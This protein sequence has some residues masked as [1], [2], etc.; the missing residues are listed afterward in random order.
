MVGIIRLG[1]TV[2]DK[3]FVVDR[4]R[5]HPCYLFLLLNTPGKFYV[6]GSWQETPAGTV[7]VFQPGQK[8]LYGY[9]GKDNPGGTYADCWT[10][11]ESDLPLFHKVNFPF[12]KPIKTRNAAEYRELF[13]LILRE[14]FGTSDYKKK[15]MHHLLSA[16]LY[17]VENEVGTRQYPDL[18]YSML[19]MRTDFYAN[20]GMDWN[21]REMAEQLNISEGY[22]HDSYKRYFGTTCMADVIQARIEFACEY[23]DSTNKSVE[24]VAELCGYHNTEHFIRQFKKK[25]GCTPLQYKKQSF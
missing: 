3:G 22:L 12:G 7:V 13:R 5:G 17:K 10:H 20:P 15:I 16:L 6:D 2:H 4:S 1:E 9:T 11:I 18:Y 8:H 19:D 25:M 14:Y 24:E 23:L 21:I